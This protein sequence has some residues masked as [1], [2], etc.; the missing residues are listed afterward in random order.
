[1]SRLLL[2]GLS[3]GVLE[4]FP[5]GTQRWDNVASTSMQR[6]HDI[7]STLMWFCINVISQQ[8]HNVAKTS[9]QRRYNVV[10]LQR[11]CND[12]VATFGVCWDANSAMTP[13]RDSPYLPKILE[14]HIG[15]LFT[16]P[17]L[18]YE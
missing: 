5:A 2:P 11:R 18:K 12:V 17:I 10:T 14:H 6:H 1:M 9:L 8:T 7:A 3:N 13:I 16:I 15:R 4:W